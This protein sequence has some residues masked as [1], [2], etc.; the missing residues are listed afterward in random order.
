MTPDDFREARRKL[1]L[2]AQGMADA[3]KL[4][5]NGGRTVRR[6]EAGE[7]DIP[8]PATVLVTLWTDPRCPPELRPTPS[9]RYSA[10]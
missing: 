1:C 8:G 4:G 10:D 2:S 3:L 9:A 6:W 5:G 7:N